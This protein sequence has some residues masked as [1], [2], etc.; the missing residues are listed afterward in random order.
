MRFNPDP[1]K[2]AQEVIFSLKLQKISLPSIYFNN[3]PMEKVLSQKHLEMILDTKL[4]FKE[5]IKN[6]I[7]SIKLLDY[8]G[9][10]KT[11]C[12]EDHYLQF[13][14]HFSGLILILVMLYNTKVIIILFWSQY[15]IT[16]HWL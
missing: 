9:S 2:E 15:N 12:L 4:N 8:Y 7:K 11:S 16:Q 5:H 1:N 13:L 3:N 14:N 6:I 10:C